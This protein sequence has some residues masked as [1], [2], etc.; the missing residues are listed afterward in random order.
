MIVNPAAKN[1]RARVAGMI[2][3]HIDLANFDGSTFS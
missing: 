1:R 3:R 2:A